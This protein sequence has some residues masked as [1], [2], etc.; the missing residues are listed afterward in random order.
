MQFLSRLSCIKFQTCSRP[1]RYCSNKS[2][3]KSHLVYMCDFALSCRNKNRL[4]KRR[5]ESLQLLHARLVQTFHQEQSICTTLASIFAWGERVEKGDCFLNGYSSPAI[6][7]AVKR[8]NVQFQKK[9]IPP[10]P[11][12]TEGIGI[13]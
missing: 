2:P 6:T 3:W 10:P 1:L 11:P 13:S 9:S 7:A 8:D 12:P 4:C 5:L